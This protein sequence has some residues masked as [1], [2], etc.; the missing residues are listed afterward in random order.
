MSTLE[1]ETGLRC[2]FKTYRTTP[3][4]DGR[5]HTEVLT[6]A[7]DHTHL[8]HSDAPYALVI[9]R[10]FADKGELKLVILT[11]NSPHLLLVFREVVKK[12]TT[13]ASDFT[14]PF[15][16]SSP[17]QMLVHYW[18]ELDKYRQET[19]NTYVLQHLNLL[20]D[21]MEHEVGPDR[22]K[23]MTMLRA[24]GQ[25]T[26]LNAWV[27]F[28]PGCLL[29]T[30]I[31]GHPWLLRCEKTAYETSTNIGPYMEVH[32]RYTD[33]VG[34][35]VGQVMHTVVVRQKRL[36]GAENPAF[37]TDLPIY[38]R[39]FV[40]GQDGLEERLRERGGKFL[41][42]K[43]MSVEAYD[44]M[45]QYLKEPPYSWYDP[46]EGNYG[47]IWLPYAVSVCGVQLTCQ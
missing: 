43:N 5:L 29:Y 7:F 24:K 36:F 3:K 46:D 28:R 27:I 30:Q 45:A 44:G 1:P 31:M 15:E 9:H 16:L 19:E 41:K 12:Y 21:F 40:E 10:T 37:V 39:E 25:I 34:T 2:E 20:F 8:G 23:I 17:F 35:L 22:N 42:F 4:K 18:D 38:P 26:Y 6:E 33:D 32:C 14:R 11:I 47:G 13:V